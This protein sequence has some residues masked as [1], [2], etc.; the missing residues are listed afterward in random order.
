MWGRSGVSP[1]PG[2]AAAGK[3]RWAVERETREERN[4]W[5]K[6][7]QVRVRVRDGLLMRKKLRRSIAVPS[8]QEKSVGMPFLAEREGKESGDDSK[9]WGRARGKETSSRAAGGMPSASGAARLRQRKGRRGTGRA[10][11]W[12]RLEPGAERSAARQGGREAATGA[13]RGT[14]RSAFPTDEQ[15][16]SEAER[17]SLCL[18]GAE[19]R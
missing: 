19:G 11:D 14:E 7:T 15:G 17:E 9:R 8:G 10:R 2:G 5:V 3:W 6:W 4:L 13:E 12:R 1:E 16:K 18:A